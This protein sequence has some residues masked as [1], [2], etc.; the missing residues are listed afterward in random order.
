MRAMLFQEELIARVR[1]ACS[2]DDGL[3]A[4]LMYGSFAA[5]EADQHSDIEFWLF[6][7]LSA[8]PRSTRVRGAGALRRFPMGCST[9][10]AP[11]WRSSRDWCGGSSTSRRWTTSLAWPT[12]PRVVRRWSGCWWWTVEVRWSRCCEPCPSGMSRRSTARRWS[13][14]IA[15]R[16]ST[17]SCLRITWWGVARYPRLGR[18]R[19]RSASSGVDGASGRAVHC[20]LADAGKGC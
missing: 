18:P 16:L 10:S 2:A 1:E 14:S 12:G 9:G 15:T 8:A 20:A 4:A 7:T 6:F 19:A 13:Q 11:S 17:G 5:G 3:D